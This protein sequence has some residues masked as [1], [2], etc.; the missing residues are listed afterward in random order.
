MKEWVD[1]QLE[2][3]TSVA[4]AEGGLNSDNDY[5]EQS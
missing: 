1:P 3:L 4:Q 2:I 5:L